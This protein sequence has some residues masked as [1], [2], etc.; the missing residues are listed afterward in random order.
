[1]TWHT[2]S[3]ISAFAGFFFLGI[4]ILLVALGRPQGLMSLLD[5]SGG[6]RA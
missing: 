4:A 5:R 1:M 6:P 3:M 2:L